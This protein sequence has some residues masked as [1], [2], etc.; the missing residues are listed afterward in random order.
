MTQHGMSS[1]NRLGT[2]QNRRKGTK[3]DKEEDAGRSRNDQTKTQRTYT[4]KLLQPNRAV[5][6]DDIII[7][8]NLFNCVSHLHENG[9]GFMQFCEN[10][11]C[12]IQILVVTLL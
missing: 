6:V 3:Y 8:G 1:W 9:V 11:G 7:H 12:F 4:V 10:I 2:Q 5:A